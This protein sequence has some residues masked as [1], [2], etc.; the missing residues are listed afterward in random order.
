MGFLSILGTNAQEFEE[1]QKVVASDRGEEDR[2]GWSCDID[3]NYAVVGAYAD[4]YGPSD[5]NM[6]AV[7]VYE[8]IGGEWVEIQK[9]FNLDQDDYDRFGWSV[10]IDGDYI[11]V[12]AYGEDEDENDENTLSKAGSAYIFEKDG[13]EWVQVQKLVAFDRAAD[14]EFGW[15]VAIHGNT[16]IVGAHNDDKDAAGMGFMYHAGSAYIFDRDGDGDWN[17]S[18]KIVASDR[19]PGTE[20]EPDHEDWNDRFGE[21]VGIWNDYVVVGGPFASKAYAFERSGGTWTE[22][23]FLTY[24]GISWLDRAAPV[25]IDS[26]TIAL[27]ASTED[28]DPDGGESIL[29]SGGAA[30][31]KR[32]GGSWGFH[33]KIS[34]SDRDAGDHFGISISIDGDYLVV[35]CHSDNHDEFDDDEIENTGSLYVFEVG[36]DGFYDEIKKLDASDRAEDDELGIS[37]S[38]SGNTIISGAWQQSELPE[39]GDYIEDAGAAYLYSTEEPGDGCETVFY[40][41][42]AV[43]C[44]GEVFEVG[45]SEYDEEGVYTDVIET[46]A[47]CDSV[48]TT[49]LEVID[50]ISIEQEFFLCDGESVTVGESTYDETGL[51]ID[52]FTSE[53]GCDSLVFTYVE[54]ADPINVDVDTEG[55]LLEAHAEDVDYQW[56]TCDPF[57]P[58]DGATDQTYEAPEDGFYAVIIYDGDC[59]DTSECYEINTSGLTDNTT[60]DF[61]VFPNPNNGNFV[62]NSQ[63]LV[64]S[65][66]QIFNIAGELIYED[67]IKSNAEQVQIEDHPAG[68]YLIRITTDSG[69]LV[70][71]IVLEQINLFGESLKFIDKII[72]S[73][74]ATYLSLPCKRQLN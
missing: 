48:V 47:G 17:F 72:F 11:I 6:G 40:T 34:P 70:D 36:D 10:A 20:Y 51:Y 67:Y 58:I 63:Q 65:R 22:V 35:G 56:I 5:P 28:H 55:N 39:G 50:E 41:Q 18:Q 45:D 24:P 60:T 53:F 66:L 69:T 71:K 31:F 54:V 38:I 73:F 61:N 23:A 52:E 74:F 25:S 26:T 59:V 49:I 21:S 3:G 1:I 46:E 13:D 42:E 33:Q 29:N 12:G 44:S 62:I 57:E 9:L 68:L 32:V 37:V 8:R 14:D 4:D 15:S 2:L 27:G 43:I 30:V 19:S 7:Y 64:G 16:A